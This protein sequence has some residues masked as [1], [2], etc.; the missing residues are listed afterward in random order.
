M[1]P[2]AVPAA[3]VAD[4][5]D[6]VDRID[7]REFGGL[8]DA[9]DAG[10]G[11]VDV[12]TPLDGMRDPGGRELAA[13]AGK[14]EQLRAVGEKLR[15]PALIRF[16]VRDLVAEDRVVRLAHGGEGQ[17]VGGRA[18]EHEKHLRRALEDLADEF[19]GPG[20]PRV[21]AV[22]RLALLVGPRERFP[23]PGAHRGRVVTG[24]L[25]VWRDGRN[26][27]G[28]ASFCVC[29]FAARGTGAS[30]MIRGAYAAGRKSD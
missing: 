24:E 5:S 29:V 21:V 22:A 28:E 1:Q 15:G 16:D 20:R 9:H 7:G 18:V 3:G 6:L 27:H 13:V 11:I 26:R 14:G 30:P 10:L 25:A 2:Q 12:A 19:A 17:R 8:R 23:R 4:S